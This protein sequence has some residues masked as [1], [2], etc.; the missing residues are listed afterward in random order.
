MFQRENESLQFQLEAYKNEID[1]VK[2][3]TM[4]EME[5][6]KAQF[7]ARQALQVALDK[8]VSNNFCDTKPI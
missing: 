4:K 7:I 5:K 6:F 1:V 3:D 2:S 8:N